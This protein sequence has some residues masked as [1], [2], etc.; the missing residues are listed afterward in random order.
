MRSKPSGDG[1]TASSVTQKI[2]TFLLDQSECVERG[3][4]ILHVSTF[5]Y[6][7]KLRLPINPLSLP[8]LMRHDTY[9]STRF[10][11]KRLNRPLALDLHVRIALIM[12]DKP[13]S[14]SYGAKN[15]NQEGRHSGPDG[16]RRDLSHLA[17]SNLP[18]VTLQTF[19]CMFIPIF[20]LTKHR[21]NNR[22]LLNSD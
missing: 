15:P 8:L 21:L 11:A 18:L 13:G 19:I 22:H 16:P 3:V 10:S 12:M 20:D 7:H 17:F 2:D 5:V 4:E 1:K 14:V 9:T 6:L